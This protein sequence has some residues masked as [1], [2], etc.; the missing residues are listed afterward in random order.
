MQAVDL[1]VVLDLENMGVAGNE[2]LCRLFQQG[3]FGYGGIFSGITADM[4]H[5][6]LYFLTGEA[7]FLRVYASDIIPVDIAINASQWFKGFQFISY[8]SGAKIPRMPD[9]IAIFKMFENG[10]IQEVMGIRQ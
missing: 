4:D 7:K 9:L 6:H 10:V 3:C 2:E 5:Q 8:F 1:W